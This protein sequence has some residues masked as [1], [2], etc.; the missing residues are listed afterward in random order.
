MIIKNTG[1]TIIDNK[2]RTSYSNPCIIRV[3]REDNEKHLK[4]F[5]KNDYQH[6]FQN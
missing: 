4:Q 3:Y 1:D 2:S 5:I 6:I